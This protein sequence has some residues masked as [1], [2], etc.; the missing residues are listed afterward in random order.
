[1]G[2]FGLGKF[3]MSRSILV[4]LLTSRSAK[5]LKVLKKS[6]FVTKVMLNQVQFESQANVMP[7]LKSSYTCLL[8]LAVAMLSGCATLL[9]EDTQEVKVRLLCGER[10][11]VSTC[12]LQNGRGRWMLATPG[13]SLILRDNSPLEITCKA[14]YVPS[15]TVSAL[16]MPST[17]MVGNILAGGVIGAAVD[18]YNNTGMKYPENID[19]SNPNCK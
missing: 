2:L 16:P 12:Y 4:F 14:P 3:M 1:M 13:R 8:V 15:F 18:I 7:Q 5:L 11:I 17:S 19:I 10:N 6:R 9:E